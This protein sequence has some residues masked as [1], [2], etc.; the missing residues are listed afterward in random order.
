MT[1]SHRAASATQA[2]TVHPCLAAFLLL[3]V[4]LAT[5]LLAACGKSDGLT[6]PSVPLTP[7]RN[8]V[9]TW[10]TFA[11]SPFYYTSDFCGPS[12]ETVATANWAITWIITEVAGDANKVRIQMNTTPTGY[13]RLTSSCGTGGNGWV[14]FVSPQFFTATVSGAAITITDAT[15]GLSYVGAFTSVSMD[16]AW[17]RWDC[18]IY[19]SGEFTKQDQPLK[20]I[21]Q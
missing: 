15:Q 16:G 21:K 14:P 6:G 17:S 5:M 13:Q 2:Q 4:L 1:T 20:L 3:P 7:V 19:C 8:I 11:P 18:I 12:K 9:G 10:K